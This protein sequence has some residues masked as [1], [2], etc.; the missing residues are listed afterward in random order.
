M[1]SMHVH[2]ILAAAF[3]CGC[4]SKVE[5]PAPAAKAPAV[6]VT[7]DQLMA[8]LKADKA[9]AETKYAKKRIIITGTVSSLEDGVDLKGSGDDEVSISLKPSDAA[10]LKGKKI[11]AKVSIETEYVSSAPDLGMVIC[12]D[13][14]MVPLQEPPATGD[15]GPEKPK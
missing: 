13:G 10:K 12:M 5:Q 8:A 1:K 11:G 4:G 2:C 6:V 14:K 15:T 3:L 9:A 7:V